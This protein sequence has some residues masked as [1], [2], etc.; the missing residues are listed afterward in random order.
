VRALTN[1]LS[2]AGKVAAMEKINDF[3]NFADSMFERLP[4]QTYATA[5]F[6]LWCG[7]G[8]VGVIRCRKRSA[9]LQ[10]QLDN[11]SRHVHQLE[12]AESRRLIE[13][14]NSSSCSR[15][16]LQQQDASS[17]VPHRERNAAG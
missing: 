8:L 4:H 15:S 5:L 9:L 13:L 2:Q 1:E 17:I 16:R 6:V 12:L 3:I 11:L 7:L 10:K 14:L